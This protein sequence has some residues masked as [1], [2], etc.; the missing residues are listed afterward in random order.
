MPSKSHR[1]GRF[2][3]QRLPGSEGSP[4]PS[5]G[6]PLSSSSEGPAERFRQL[7]EDHV[8]VH[9]PAAQDSDNLA[10]PFVKH[11]PG[12]YAYVVNSCTET[13]F[14]DVGSLRDHIK[15]VHSR[16]YGCTE[17]YSH[18]FNCGKKQLGQAKQKH[19]GAK[20]CKESKKKL[21]ERKESSEPEWMTEAQEREYET[22]DLRRVRLDNLKES[23]REI[24]THL[25]PESKADVSTIPTHCYGPG[26]LVSTFVI[27][28]IL[29]Q[30]H[31]RQ[32]RR[33]LSSRL[34]SQQPPY[35]Q[36]TA[37]TEDDRSPQ[38]PGENLD[39]ILGANGFDYSV[40]VPDPAPTAFI[41]SNNTSSN[42]YPDNNSSISNNDHF[43]MSPAAAPDEPR[44]PPFS[45]I[46]PGST[47]PSNQDSA[48]GTN[49][50]DENE[51][52]KTQQYHQSYHSHNAA[53]FP[54]TNWDR[55]GPSGPEQNPPAGDDIHLDEEGVGDEPGSFYCSSY[56]PAEGGRYDGVLHSTSR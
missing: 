30:L 4:S 35:E 28:Q 10:C 43:I 18:R 51:G 47:G 54:L 25:W 20:E 12:R 26:F 15:R 19:Q 11:N 16:K 2:K 22:L 40:Y 53:S 45:Y 39:G 52:Y 41:S 37:E 32:T 27:D 46:I 56:F 7:L 1:N 44:V 9:S 29:E 24:Y 13:G 23:F 3:R 34:P 36:D 42:N 55:A 50:S 49:L 14:K 38:P 21:D 31:I 48:Y 8:M 6:P 33:S 5:P 17:C